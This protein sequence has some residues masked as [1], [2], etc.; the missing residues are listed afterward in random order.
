MSIKCLLN[1][2]KF[3]YKIWSLSFYFQS[4]VRPPPQSFKCGF[5]RRHAPQF[6]IRWSSKSPMKSRVMQTTLS[7]CP[8]TYA[9]LG[10]YIRFME[11]NYIPFAPVF[12]RVFLFPLWHNSSIHHD[13][14]CVCIS[15]RS[16]TAS[17]SEIA[18]WH[19]HRDIGYPCSEKKKNS[20]GKHESKDKA[21]RQRQI[22]IGM[23]R[24]TVVRF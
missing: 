17:P 18:I 5:L 14:V 8:H 1:L 6:Q 21:N 9:F 2:F 23:S 10:R 3:I 11:I 15:K 20:L 19:S 13:G 12:L 7:S 24:I 22:K 16:V 4:T